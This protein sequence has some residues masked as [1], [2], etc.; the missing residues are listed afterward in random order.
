MWH[1][2]NKAGAWYLMI[3]AKAEVQPFE[4]SF[5]RVYTE[6]SYWKSPCDGVTSFQD[7]VFRFNF[8]EG[9]GI[10]VKDIMES[11][12]S[13][14]L[15]GGVKWTVGKVGSGVYFGDKDDL[16]HFPEISVPT[17]I[18]M[19]HGTFTVSMWVKPDALTTHQIDQEGT[20]SVDGVH[21]Q[22]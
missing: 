19:V 4:L 16:G 15:Q 1:K 8:D 20:A 5:E 7:E 12:A 14:I 10:V 11:D 9:Q 13:G 22:T 2:G 17:R 6:T 3:A 18:A 21:G